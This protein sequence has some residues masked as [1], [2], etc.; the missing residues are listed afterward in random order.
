MRKRAYLVAAGAMLLFAACGLST[1]GT[2]KGPTKDG[3]VGPGLDASGSSSGSDDHDGA[4]PDGPTGA[5]ATDATSSDAPPSDGAAGDAT[6]AMPDVAKEAAP[7]G[8]TCGTGCCSSAGECVS[9]CASDPAGSACLPT[10]V[11]GCAS[12]TECSNGQACSP[13]GACT[14]HCSATSLCKGSGCCSS[15]WICVD[16]CSSD[17]AGQSCMSGLCGCGNNGDCNDQEACDT[18]THACTFACSAKQQCNDGCC[19]SAGVCASGCDNDPAGQNCESNGVCGCDSQDDCPEYQACDTTTHTCTTACSAQS[20][21][22]DGCCSSGNSCVEDCTGDPAG[23]QCV[24]N[25]CGCYSMGD[26]PNQ[27]ACNNNKCP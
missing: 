18:T 24:N 23:S 9:D 26:C 20:N 15:T 10:K 14:L 4:V 16:D 17:P 12:N 25:A 13:Q 11:C 7:C 27:G 6:D 8:G 1:S 5:D 21:C 3:S 2:G 19:S 22:N